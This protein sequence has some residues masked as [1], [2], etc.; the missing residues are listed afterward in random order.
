MMQIPRLSRFTLVC[1]ALSAVPFFAQDAAIQEVHGIQV[2]HLD[3][4]VKPGDDFY[5]FAN[6]EWLR[7]TQIPP[8]RAGVN[9]FTRLDDLAN[10][11]TADLIQEIAKSNPAP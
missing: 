1:L 8:D 7:Q 4:S 11:R 3:R 9:V 2:Y 5:Q 6:G 10:Q